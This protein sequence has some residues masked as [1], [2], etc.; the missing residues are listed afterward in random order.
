MQVSRQSCK[1]HL[2]PLGR[3]LEVF[4]LH[5]EDADAQLG[6]LPKCVLSHIYGACG[7]LKE[8]CWSQLE[9]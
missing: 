9:G 7:A 5:R 1:P 8:P 6:E 3:I 4:I 2:L